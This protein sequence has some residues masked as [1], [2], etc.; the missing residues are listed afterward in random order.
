MSAIAIVGMGARFADAVDLPAYWDALKSGH[1]A[2]GPVPE[3]RWPADLFFSDNRRATDKTYA[4]HGA[5]IKD[6]R[7][8]PALAL[9]LPPRRVEVMDPQQRLAIEIALNTIEDAGYTPDQMPHRTGVFVGITAQEYRSLTSVRVAAMMMAT[10]QYGRAPEDPT[11]FIE[12][13]ENLVPSRPY[14]AP[15]ALGNMSAAA[16]AQ[17]LDLHGPAYTTDAACASAHM[18]IFDAVQQ[19]RSGAIDAALAGGSYVQITADHYL[20]FARIGAMSASGYCRPFDHRADGFVQGDGAA[21]MLLKRLDD[22]V[23]DGDRIYAVI[24]GVAINN[25]GR[26]DGPMAPLQS[27]QT[28]VIN[29]AWDDAGLDKSQYGYHEAH[30]TGTAVGDPTEM[31]GLAAAIGEHLSNPIPV[32]SA[33]ANIGHTMSTAGVAGLMRATLAVHHGIIPPMAGFEKPN[34]ALNLDELPFRI[35]TE[36]EAW[37]SDVRIAGCSAFGFGGTN[38]H[39]IIRNHVSSAPTR[40][41]AAAGTTADADAHLVLMSGPDMESLQ[42]LV[43]RTA[44]AVSHQPDAT[45]PGIARAWATRRHQAAR[46]GIVATS[47][48]DFIEKARAFSNGEQVRGVRSGIATDDELKIAFLYPGQGAQRLGM[49]RDIRERFPVVRETLDAMEAAL[50]DILDTPL[51]ELIYPEL[52]ENGVDETEAARELTATENCQPAMLASGVALTE[53]LSSVGVNPTVV[54]GHSLGE[55]TA[56]AIGGVLSPS[57]AAEFVARRGRAMADLNGDHGTMAA[58]MAEREVVEGLLVDGAIVANV[59]HPRQL[60]VSGFTP[61]VEQVVERAQAEGI[62]AVPLQVSHGFHSPALHQLNSQELVAGLSLGQPHTPVASG[63]IDRLYGSTEDAIEVFL[64]HATSPVEFVRALDQCREAG[65]NLYLQVGAGGPLASFARGSLPRDHHGILTLAGRNDDDKGTSLLETLSQLWCLGVPVDVTAITDA[66]ALPT[67]PSTVLPREEYWA[68]KHDI[69]LPIEI[70]GNVHTPRAREERVEAPAVSAE[71]DATPGDSDTDSLE[72]SVLGIIAKVSAYPKSALRKDMTLV[73]DLGFDSLMVGDLATGLSEAFEHID[74]IPQELLIN[75]PTV[76]DIIEFA[77]TA[78]SGPDRSAEDDLP[79]VPYRLEW[80]ERRPGTLPSRELP[81]GHRVLIVAAAG[82]SGADELLSAFGS[83]KTAVLTPEEAASASACDLLIWLQPMDS[84][85]STQPTTALITALR[86]Q[87]SHAA[88]PDLLSISLSG[89]TH[90]ASL[91][92]AIRAMGREWPGITAT[93]MHFD[94]ATEIG[95]HAFRQWTSADRTADV[96]IDASGKA[97]I[98]SFVPT[99]PTQNSDLSSHHILV[100]GGTKGIGLDFAKRAVA[101]GARVALVGRSLPSPEVQAWI[102]ETEGRATAVQAD[103]TDANALTSATQGLELTAVVHAAGILADGAVEDVD[104]QRGQAVLSIKTNGLIHAADAAR[105]SR[106]DGQRPQWLV[107]LGSW[108]GRFGNRHQSWYAAANAQMAAL[109]EGL[110]ERAVT[111]EY[112]PWS[113]SDMVKQIPAPVQSAMRSEGIDFVGDEAGHNALLAAT[114]LPTGIYTLGRNLPQTQRAARA[115]IRLST[116]THPY[117]LDHAIEGV[118]VLPLAGATDLMAWV[119][120][121]T[122]PFEVC[123]VRLFQGVTVSEPVSL[124]LESN[125]GKVAIRFAESGALAYRATV[126]AIDPSTIEST[127]PLTGGETSDLTVEDF[128]GITFHGPALAGLASVDGVGDDFARGVIKVGTPDA[129]IPSTSRTAWAV[130][131]LAL[132]SAMQLSAFVAWQRYRR[133][134]TPVGIKRFVKLQEFPTSGE[135]TAE[136]R[137]GPIEGDRFTGTLLFRDPSTGTLLALAEDV[138][139]ELRRAEDGEATEVEEEAPFEIKPEWVDFSKWKEVQDLEMRLAMA[140]LGGIENPFFRVQEGTAKDTTM[141][142]GKEYINFSSYNYIGLSGDPRILASVRD[143]VDRYGTSVSASR[144]ASGERPFHG[145]LEKV[146]AAAQR[147]ADSLVF[148]A[149]HATNVTTIGHLFGPDDLIVHDEYIH[150]SGLQGIKL[151]GA[152]RRMFAHDDP[153]A[154]EAE[155]KKLRRH[156][157][158]VLILVEGVYSMDGDICALPEYIRL[159]KKYGCMLM[160][161]EAH[162]FGVVGETGKGLAE[163]F[164]THPDDVDIWMGTLSKSLASCGGWIS[165]DESLIRYLRYTAP[166]FVYSAGLTAA[167]GVAAVESMKYMLE[168]PWRVKKLQSNANFFQERLEKHG[169]DTGPAKGESGVVPAITGNSMWALQLAQRLNHAGINVQPIVYPAVPDDASR[170]RFFLSSTHSHEQL[171]HTAD[172]VASTLEEVKKDFPLP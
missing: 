94:A 150:D 152:A 163:H 167:N 82:T 162:S 159:K 37:D 86:N 110:A 64:N 93:N 140:E 80:T 74:G 48:D 90:A 20:V 43:G 60:V 97:W 89:D 160:V 165:G 171:G 145:E 6:I 31:Q 52:R 28:E 71:A 69:Q 115:T 134:G 23:R 39:I 108:A 47:I 65:A 54:V 46:V 153:E 70:P 9:G 10:G 142:N 111:V 106:A 36:A 2:F 101:R 114:T 161:D 102:S 121:A 141:M 13:V 76:S 45:V 67:L 4:P 113:N 112:G 22:A 91:R 116:E 132:D 122:A 148:T 127:E 123:D 96:R 16:V 149:G 66:A 15:G 169:V 118:P 131:P 11:A 104:I 125:G 51:N 84:G 98:R 130:D 30:G 117:L 166:G 136:V 83:A 143:A 17:E 172:L 124:T 58:V 59:N 129:W 139:A 33:K 73:D 42:D 35:P 21:L 62:K 128:Y 119:A 99:A 120:E 138:V 100:T 81:S 126:R 135:L 61:A 154:C 5:F 88:T 133:A 68:I 40:P 146:L 107:T 72:S 92:G 158:K 155:L 157:K 14:A 56:A 77:R 12:A 78:K 57:D 53:L 168:E 44:T 170:L 109:A 3:N 95:S 79:L 137:F 50:D 103:V 27:G 49:L 63:I 34:P 75:R 29:Q 32:G 164:D 151:S 41:S 25:D 24:E 19:L 8:F 1:Q 7:S 105:A 85:W 147:K 55:F 144:V 87:A 38:G 18:A 156:Y 26:G